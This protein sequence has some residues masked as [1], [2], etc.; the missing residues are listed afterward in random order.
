MDEDR[1]SDVDRRSGVEIAALLCAAAGIV[2]SVIPFTGFV[3]PLGP[4]AFTMRPDAE[5]LWSAPLGILIAVLAIGACLLVASHPRRAGV[6]LLAAAAM[7]TLDVLTFAA[8]LFFLVAAVCAFLT[9]PRY[10]TDSQ[11]AAV[12]E[13]LAAPR[14]QSLGAIAATARLVQY[15]KPVDPA[16]VSSSLARLDQM[17]AANELEESTYQ[18]YSGLLA[19]FQSPQSSA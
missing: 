10:P 15:G 12:A 11:S 19:G 5:I 9:K 1:V 17:H 2:L 8:M 13:E 4:W 14:P 18:E 7:T 6:M 16:R 3:I